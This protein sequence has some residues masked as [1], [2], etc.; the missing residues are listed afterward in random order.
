MSAV[1]VSDILYICPV[2]SKSLGWASAYPGKKGEKQ[3]FSVIEFW[4]S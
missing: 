3:L 4:R 1:T 2:S